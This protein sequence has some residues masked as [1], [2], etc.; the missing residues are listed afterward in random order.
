[1]DYPASLGPLLASPTYI[2]PPQNFIAHLLSQGSSGGKAP[3]KKAVKRVT[4]GAHVPKAVARGIDGALRPRPA[5]APKVAL[6]DSGFMTTTD[7]RLWRAKL[8]LPLSEDQHVCH[9]IAHSRGGAD[10][11][12]NYFAASGS[13]NQSLGN[14]NDSFLAEVAGLV[15]TKRAVA[16]SR[17]T[18]YKGP[19]AEELIAMARTARMNPWRY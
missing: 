18:G 16:I 13:L 4:V 19:G 17:T 12:D 8:G 1:M 10:H 9:I 5:H 14:R 11:R 15:Q 7:Y 6:V 2:C 3:A